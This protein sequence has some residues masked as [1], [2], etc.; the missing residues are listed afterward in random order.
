MTFILFCCSDKWREASNRGVHGF[1]NSGPEVL[2]IPR[3]DGSANYQRSGAP[4][5]D[6]APERGGAQHHDHGRLRVP[7]T[8]EGLPSSHMGYRWVKR[9]PRSLKEKYLTTYSIVNCKSYS[10]VIIT[11]IE[12][13]YRLCKLSTRILYSF[14]FRVFTLFG[15]P[16][17][18]PKPIIF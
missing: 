10:F 14:N 1:P 2:R 3:Q 7:A 5:S 17:V 16:L 12:N 9:A 8:L 11:K 4:A 18:A 13:V 6:G 15:Q